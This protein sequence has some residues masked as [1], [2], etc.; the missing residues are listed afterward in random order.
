MTL[1]PPAGKVFAGVAM[2]YD[3]ADFTRRTGH[4]PAVWE[5]FIAFDQTF[6]WAIDLADR[7][8]TRLMLAVSTAA[9]Q[10]RPGTIAPGGIA[11]GHGD[12]WLLTMRNAF[13]AFGRPAYLRF[14]GEMNNCH[15]A[16]A[17]LSCS[18]ASR[19]SRYSAQAFVAAWRRTAAIMR[20]TSFAQ[21]NRVLHGLH[22]HALRAPPVPL[23]PARIAMVWSPMTAG[24]PVV[25][26][27]DPVRFWPGRRWVDWVGTSFYSKYPN[28][29]WLGPF[30][31]RFAQRYH[32]PFVFAEWAMWE[33]GDPGFV[34]SV[35]SWTAEHRLTRM[36]VYNQGKDPNGPFRLKHFPSAAQVLRDGLAGRR[37][38][39]L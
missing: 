34:R 8:E 32:R 25:S 30:Y 35:L 2:G 27:L 9:G 20:G 24:S 39:V 14:L 17:P 22:Q 10:D 18:G 19:G 7:A 6:Q 16:Y 28:F 29:R 1:L 13:A 3:V 23:V 38:S 31:A 5:Q 37:F 12:R 33:N 21:I 26:S 4:K 36:L 11:A 15:N